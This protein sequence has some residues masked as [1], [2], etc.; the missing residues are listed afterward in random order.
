M[1]PPPSDPIR[2]DDAS[3]IDPMG[4]VF[5]QEGR[6]YRAI[7]P[8]WTDFYRDLLADETVA[9]LMAEGRLV[10][11]DIAPDI[12]ADGFGLVL[13]HHTVARPN[14]GYEWPM[15]ML[16][17]A[18]RLTLDLALALLDKG[19]LLQDAAGPNVFFEGGKPVFIDFTS[20]A[21]AAKG[22]LWPAYQQ[23]CAFFLYPLYLHAAGRSATALKLL[24]SSPEGLSAAEAA[25]SLGLRHKLGLKGYLG[26]VAL[27]EFMTGRSAKM[28]SRSKMAAASD[29]LTQ[30]VDLTAAR[31]RFLTGLDKTVAGLKAP[32]GTG[33]WT[34]YYNQTDHQVLQDKL[35]AVESVLERIKPGSVLDVGCN[36]GAFSEL[37]AR[38]GAEV[39]AVDSDHDSVERLY[40]H[41]KD[42]GLAITPLVADVLNPSPDLGWRNREYP[43]LAG[44]LKSEA[45][46]ALALIHHLVFSGGQD[47]DRSLACLKDFTS[48]RL[49]IEYV[50]RTDP[51]VEPLPRR[52]GVDYD[53]Y[54]EDNFKAALGRTFGSV[55]EVARLSQTRIL[56]AAEV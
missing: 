31:K 28:G 6:I 46:L 52:P 43:A 37:A 40:G 30:K 36:T 27:P 41:I 34:D 21:P 49:I 29:R 32:A 54:T 45:V 18:A 22:Y 16:R 19:V 33:T 26:R 35:A 23:F 47:F 50:D 42:K 12:Q 15:G 2:F 13:A 38:L 7:F 53:W 51:M 14:F 25:S 8:Q 10:Q 3:F 1:T 17:D 48:R 4:R 24:R 39:T 9:R 20:L 11:T 55:E 5:R 56:F 44:R